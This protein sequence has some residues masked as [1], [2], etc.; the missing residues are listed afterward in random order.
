LA[1][2][3]LRHLELSRRRQIQAEWL[4]SPTT[5]QTNDPFPQGLH[6]WGDVSERGTR[7]EQERAFREALALYVDVRLDGINNLVIYTAIARCQLAL[8]V[9]GFALDYARR[10]LAI[11]STDVE[12]LSIRTQAHLLDR[13]PADALECAEIWIAAHS[14]DASA[15]YARGRALFA[16]GRF[17]EARDAFDRASALDQ[18][19]ARGVRFDLRVGRPSR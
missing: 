10:A 17:E 19:A 15:R 7:L 18:R 11:D 14:L 4:D 6:A 8:G 1:S 12:A 3:G 5:A 9:A 2:D 16:L 13:K